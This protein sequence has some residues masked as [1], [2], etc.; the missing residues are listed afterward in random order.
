MKTIAILI[1]SASIA[2]CAE[3]SRTWTDTKGRSIEG[4]LTAKTDKTATVQ[5]ANGKRVDLKLETLSEPDKEY[6]T[7][8]DLTPEVENEDLITS[9]VS[10]MRKGEKTVEVTARAGAK[11]LV[12]VAR[13]ANGNIKGQYT[14]AKGESKTFQFVTSDKYTVTGSVDGVVLD[15]E[16]D[17]K[18]TGISKMLAP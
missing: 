13:N 5:T 7:K 11:E 16:D 4:V 6:V 15:S 17:R 14:V 12:V 18:K 10:A 8:A 3:S 1:L 2:I 9:R